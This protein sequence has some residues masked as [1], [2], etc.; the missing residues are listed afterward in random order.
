[1]KE[2]LD[3]DIK[4]DSYIDTIEY[5]YPSFHL[6]MD[7]FLVS[8]VHGNIVLKEHQDAKW[9]SKEELDSVTWLPADVSLIEKL[10]KLL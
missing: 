6:V 7:C 8:I 3:V 2:E 10:K 1:M 5:D 9:L 4:V